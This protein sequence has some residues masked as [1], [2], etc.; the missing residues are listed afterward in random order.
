METELKELLV[1][2]KKCFISTDFCNQI[3]L[4]V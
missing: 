1:L 2:L 4:N 3:D